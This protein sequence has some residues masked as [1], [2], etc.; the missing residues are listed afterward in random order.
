MKINKIFKNELKKRRMKKRKKEQDTKIEKEKEKEKGMKT[1]KVTPF[2]IYL[3]NK[4]HE[5]TP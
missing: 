2:I 5:L 4:R 3:K 1:K